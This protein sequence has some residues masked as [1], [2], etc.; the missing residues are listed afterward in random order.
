MRRLAYTVIITLIAASISPELSAQSLQNWI[1]PAN[2]APSIDA[3]GYLMRGEG[4][5]HLDSTRTYSGRSVAAV[6]LGAGV[7]S[8]AGSVLVVV[9]SPMFCY[10]DRDTRSCSGTKRTFFAGTAGGAA[11]GAAVVGWSSDCSFLRGLLYS[12]AGSALGGL[13]GYNA[14]RHG[15]SA[16]PFLIWVGT[17]AGSTAA[18]K[19]LC[20]P[21]RKLS[22]RSL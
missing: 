19:S 3:A 1:N 5:E 9:L 20:R 10:L 11:M 22:P 12:A 17:S 18:L 6:V 15:D 14:L 7:G 16:A 4:S 8:V 13:P 2:R 21:R